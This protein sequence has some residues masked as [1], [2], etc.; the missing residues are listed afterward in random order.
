MVKIYGKVKSF[1]Q[2][3][4]NTVV[5]IYMLA[6]NEI[7]KICKT[8]TDETG[9]FCFILE[10]KYENEIIYLK[11]QKGLICLMNVFKI[12][13]YINEITINDLTTISTIY[14]FNNFIVKNNIIIQDISLK[15]AIGMKENMVNKNGKLSKIILSNP[16]N[17]ETNALRTLNSLSNLLG[18]CVN[19]KNIFKRLIYLTTQNNLSTTID[20]I[21]WINKNPFE[22]KNEIF[23]LSNLNNSYYKP[24]LIPEL[25]SSWVIGLKFNK[26]GSDVNLIGGPGN[27]D[28]TS[29]GTVW[30]TNNVVQGTANSSDFAIALRPNGTP[31]TFSPIFGGGLL[32]GG[33][34]VYSK[35]NKTLMGNFGW[36]D[37]LPENGSI[38]ILNINGIPISPPEGIVNNNYRVQGLLVDKK[39]NIWMCSYGNNRIVVYLN[40]DPNNSVFIQLPNNSNPFDIVMDEKQNMFVSLNGNNTLNVP[41][42]VLKLELDN[43]NSINI[44]FE[45]EIGEN[46]IGLALDSNNNVFACSNATN[47]VFKISNDGQ[48]LD[49]YKE[50]IFSP[51]GCCIDGNDTL[52]IGNFN[53]NYIN[54]YCLTAYNSSG[55]LITTSNGIILESGGSEVLLSDGNPLYG[56][57]KP[58]CY[59]P[60]MR[61]TSVKVD[62]AGN[63]WYCNNWKPNFVVDV[64]SNP[65]GDGLIVF[66]GIGTP[67]YKT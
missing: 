11:C 62:A 39:N 66:L 16:N 29:D 14:A 23:T 44:I 3:L 34:G 49:E 2:Y 30:I 7:I 26:S 58:K 12:D 37:L 15:Y 61:A 6:N 57:N 67:V 45:L 1:S 55:K 27:L 53:T 43:I 40:S 51:W 36:G 48:I 19:N 4:S 64:D 42:K 9:K 59:L 47:S 13:E 41:S 20:V 8:E 22:N 33:F 54:K 21:S 17:L 56:Y 38:S 32:G 25:F 10:A 65:G 28:F 31:K 18:S 50:G 63:I 52:F 24:H 46:I 5:K 35:K 60:M